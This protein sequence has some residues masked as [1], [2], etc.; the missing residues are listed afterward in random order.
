MSH[1]FALSSD[2][3]IVFLFVVVVE[4]AVKI[5]FTLGILLN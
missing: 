4:Q 1:V 5:E 2:W 3:F